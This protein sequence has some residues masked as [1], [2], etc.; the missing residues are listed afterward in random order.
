MDVS[1]VGYGDLGSPVGQTLTNLSEG[2]YDHGLLQEV[3]CRDVDST[4]LPLDAVVRAIPLGSTIP[5][6]LTGISRHLVSFNHRGYSE[7][8]FDALAAHRVS[9]GID[10]LYCYT[11][12]YMRTIRA[13]GDA[14]SVVQNGTELAIDARERRRKELARIGF[15]VPDTVSLP[16][17][18]RSRYR[19]VLAADYVVVQ[20][21][22]VANS[23]YDAGVDEERLRI[24]SPG[25]DS[26]YFRP[27]ERT[28]GEFQVLYVGSINSVKGIAHLLDAWD[29][30]HALEG[31]ELVLCGRASPRFERLLEDS[32]IANLR[33]P[34]FV[35][36]LPYYQSASVF[37][38]PSL[39]DG[40]G[41][42][43]LEA[44]SCGCPVIVTEHTG[45]ADLLSDG[46][47]GFI[48]P[49]GD[50]EAITDR[51]EYLYGNPSER[52]RM[53]AAARRTA[54]D[55]TW[56][57]YVAEVAEFLSEVG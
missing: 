25:V 38:F 17:F 41:K 22:F 56:E 29:D 32:S 14:I 10:V 28:N 40:F 33:R 54:E 44:M 57:N 53:G 27:S 48:V 37:V 6:V 11:P 9:P 31:S 15:D 36:P 50:P 4:T 42:A 20:S 43:P 23:H 24:I 49:A 5:R 18:H 8:L 2:L 51:L 34:G 30:F 3:I 19:S 26:D 46:E 39:S 13:S 7:R 55:Q 35:D 12:G 47:D 21:R 1:V 16:P 45:M 52:E